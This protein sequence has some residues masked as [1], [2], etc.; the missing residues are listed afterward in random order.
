MSIDF[1]E[2]EDGLLEGINSTDTREIQLAVLDTTDRLV[3]VTFH[4]VFWYSLFSSRGDVIKDNEIWKIEEI[5][6]SIWMKSI[7]I[8]SSI[9]WK[10]QVIADQYRRVKSIPDPSSLRHFILL[11]D[12][13]DL[14][15]ICIDCSIKV[16][17]A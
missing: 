2:L 4:D 11:S 15:I 3:Q 7:F 16:V 13:I 5:V 17:N 1:D 9:Y 6:D 8:D 12:Y 10:E 14:E